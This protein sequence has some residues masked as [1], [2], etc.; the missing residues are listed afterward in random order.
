MLLA[1][2]KDKNK[3][4]IEVW[5]HYRMVFFSSVYFCQLGLGNI[6]QEMRQ[7]C[8]L[9]ASLA[10]MGLHW[11]FV[12]ALLRPSR[13]SSSALPGCLTRP[14]FHLCQLRHEAVLRKCNF[15]RYGKR[16]AHMQDWKQ[17]LGSV[18]SSL[19]YDGQAAS[20]TLWALWLTCW[21]VLCTWGP[22]AA[23]CCSSRELCV[24]T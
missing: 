18:P 1:L 15:S 21:L 9:G 2:L 14:R 11:L 5:L 24:F 23:L 20:E 13:V 8:C 6:F 4:A 22:Q 10:Q 7:W 16:V 17:G 12:S 19:H 3:W